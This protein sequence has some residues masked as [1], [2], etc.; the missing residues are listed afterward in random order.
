MGWVSA[1][2]VVTISAS[3]GA[4]G[5]EIGPRVAE[6]LGVPFVDRA[7]SVAVARELGVSVEEASALDDNAPSRL[8]SLF[9]QLAPMASGGAVPVGGP[10]DERR[11]LEQT[12]RQIRNVADEGGC[13]ILGR[14]AAV[15]LSDHTD[16]LHVR[17]DGSREGRMQA[18]MRQHGIDNVTATDAQR[19]ND[20]VRSAYVKHNYGVDPSSPSLY[21]LVLDT[22]RLGWSP[23]EDLIVEAARLVESSSY[24]AEHEKPV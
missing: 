12:G 10:A 7:I 2:T 18:A 4:G 3:Y 13:V 14:A 17:L 21:H 19:Q 6:R 23:A 1:M 8:W 9:A 5:S 16:T 24:R 20:K 11:L 15:I 22:V